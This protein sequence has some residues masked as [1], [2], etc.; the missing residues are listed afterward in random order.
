MNKFYT[1]LIALT[2]IAMMVPASAADCYTTSDPEVTTPAGTGPN[3]GGEVYVDNDN[4]QP[5]VG[6][7]TCLFS[8]WIYEETNGIA[9]LQRDDEVKSDVAGCA[10]TV[11]GDYII[12]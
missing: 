2:A 3:A 8:T 10:G 5:V 4:C 9:G 6:D 11:D 12:F 7:G 1:A